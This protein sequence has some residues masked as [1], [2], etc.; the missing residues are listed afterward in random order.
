MSKAPKCKSCGFPIETKLPDI[1]LC[2]ER[3]GDICEPQ[4]K[5]AKRKLACPRCNGKN[6]ATERRPNGDHICGSCRH[7]WPNKKPKE[8]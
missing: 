5:Q 8:G 2:P 6:I 4:K 1:T 3:D 7:K